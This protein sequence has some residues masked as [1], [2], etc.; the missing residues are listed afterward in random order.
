MH[1]NAYRRPLAF[2]YESTGE[3][4][5]FINNLDPDPRSR[6][7]FHFHKPETLLDFVQQSD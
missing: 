4:I 7:V 6:N 1:P 5:R 3:E 2:A